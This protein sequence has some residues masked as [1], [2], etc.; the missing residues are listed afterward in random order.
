M[1]IPNRR[2][3]MPPLLRHVADGNEHRV[4]DMVNALASYFPH[5]EE[6]RNETV[7]SR[8]KIF[9]NRCKQAVA[10]LKELGLIAST[11][12]KHYKITFL[13]LEAVRRNPEIIDKKSMAQLLESIKSAEGRQSPG[14]PKPIADQVCQTAEE[15][16]EESYREIRKKLAS[17]LLARIGANSSRFF[18]DLVID[19]LIKMGYGGSREDAEAVG[20]SG[21]SG[22]DGI[23]KEDRLGLDLVYIQ[24][25]RW[26]GN[27]G[28]P[29]VQKFVGALK[30]QPSGKG[31]F[32]TTSEFTNEARDYVEKSDSRITLINGNQLTNYMIDHNVGVSV[33]KTYELKSV[34]SD[35][36]IET[37]DS[38]TQDS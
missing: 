9:N 16:I 35:Y 12:R 15:T 32:I 14:Q 25:K 28:R 3:V 8:N 18:E 20:R 37:D 7:P 33:V 31:V 5:I 6:Q 30:G 34:D 11:R 23:I 24:A 1:D 27:V 21:D 22:I 10:R 29:E 4:R 13:G 19:L 36:F 26:R 2:D 17:E 38:Q